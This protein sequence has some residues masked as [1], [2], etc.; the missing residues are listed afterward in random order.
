MS[1]DHLTSAIVTCGR[2]ANCHCHSGISKCHVSG[3]ISW[4]GDDGG[5]VICKE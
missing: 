3:D 1:D 2:G 4:A 5:D